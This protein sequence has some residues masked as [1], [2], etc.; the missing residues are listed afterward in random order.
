MTGRL[1]LRDRQRLELRE[2][3]DRVALRLFADHGY[4]AVTVETI[5]EQ[6]GVSLST[7]FRHVPAKEQLLVGGLRTG[8]AAIVRAFAERPV[9][10]PVGE[11]LAAAIL[12]RTAQFA[13]ESEIM[14]LWR[15]AMASAP[16][17]VRRTSLLSGDEVVEL[18]GLV[19]ARLGL[20][21]RA[22][23]GPG[24]LVRARLAAAEY[25]YEHWLTHDHA[26]TLHQLTR[27]ALSAAGG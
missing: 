18:V 14:E 15:R 3:I 26:R 16:L 11:S 6:A 21:Q 25:A 7:F 27:E 4:D 2:R 9:T 23:V 20:D 22:D 17:R 13:D 5:A 19:A 8:R 24:A 12:H 10:E 1:S